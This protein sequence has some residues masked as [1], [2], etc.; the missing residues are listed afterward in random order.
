MSNT[1][2]IAIDDN[3]V[4]RKNL[5]KLWALIYGMLYL[6]APARSCST[7]GTLKKNHLLLARLYDIINF[8]KDGFASARSG[9]W[10][11]RVFLIRDV[12]AWKG[13]FVKV[14]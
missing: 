4:I 14:A 5:P 3:A 12:P 2:R 6:L 8:T 1:G 13:F 10:R 7:I 11:D 9:I